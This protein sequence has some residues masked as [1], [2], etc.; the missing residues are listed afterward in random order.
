MLTQVCVGDLATAGR[1]RIF[2][3]LNKNNGYERV[4]EHPERS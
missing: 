3:T 1:V 2:T 4:T